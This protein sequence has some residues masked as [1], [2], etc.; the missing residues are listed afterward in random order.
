MDGRRSANF[1]SALPEPPRCTLAGVMVGWAAAVKSVVTLRHLFVSPGHNFF[2]R[3]GHPAGD[4][5]AADA[6]TICC[7]AGRGI[8]GDRFYDYRPDYNGQITFFAWETVEAA[9]RHFQRLDLS[10]AVF[11]RNVITA[12]LSLTGLVGERFTLG[13]V[14]FEGVA[15]AKPCYW[16]DAVVAPGAE[17]WLRGQGG[18]RAKILTDGELRRGAVECCAPGLLA[19]G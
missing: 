7:H 3:H 8:A 18:L 13:G 9:R 12:G 5:P 6:A 19:L 14:E 4:F 15:E 2:G 1:Q 16:M 10:A 17:A 11:R